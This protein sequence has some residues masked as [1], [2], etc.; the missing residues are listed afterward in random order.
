MTRIIQYQFISLLVVYT[1][2]RLLRFKLI[3]IIA[4]QSLCTISLTFD[5][6]IHIRFSAF[7]FATVASLISDWVSLCWKNN[8]K[9]L[10]PKNSI[11]YLFIANPPFHKVQIVSINT[12]QG[13]F[14]YYYKFCVTQIH[15]SKNV[16]SLLPFPIIPVSSFNIP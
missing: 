4:L 11:S 6:V 13:Y 5:I 14:S 7:G 16:F 15:Y 8:T 3:K 1:V 9:S 2:M 10:S 12:R